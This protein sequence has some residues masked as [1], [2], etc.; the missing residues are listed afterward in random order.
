MNKEAF[1]ENSKNIVRHYIRAKDDNK[2]HMMKAVFLESAIV[3]M[4]VQTE[5]ISFP[6]HSSGLEAITD[7]LVRNFSMSY[8]NVYTFCF[9]E[10]FTCQGSV[11]S[12]DWLVG[13]TEKGGGNTRVGWGR[14]DW[15]FSDG[16]DSL[17]ERLDITI[18]NMLIFTPEYSASI[19]QWLTILP[20]PFCRS[21]AFFEFMPDLEGL[22]LA[23][24]YIR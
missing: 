13:M 12:C 5:N 14:Y 7:V 15:H 17:V 8:E 23:H 22:E 19:M 18:D 2:P 6:A 9:S 21:E 20:Y 11:V 10:S 1:I 24:K 16:E 4:K 3:D